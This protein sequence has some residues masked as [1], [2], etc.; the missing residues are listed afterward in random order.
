MQH[1]ELVALSKVG[2]A[3]NG[4]QIH[5]ISVDMHYADQQEQ[6]PGPTSCTSTSL[7]DFGITTN[8]QKQIG[9]Q[10]GRQGEVLAI[11]TVANSEPGGLPAC[12][13]ASTSQRHT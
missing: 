8:L 13:G 6:A 2:R 12:N 4:A 9:R 3:S 5:G 10:V 7:S 1:L 11:K